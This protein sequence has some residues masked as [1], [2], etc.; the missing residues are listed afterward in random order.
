MSGGT[1]VVGIY[2][3]TLMRRGHRVCVVSLPRGQASFKEKLKS[4]LRGRDSSLRLRSHL[5]EAELDHRVLDVWRPVTD[6]DVPDG[7]IVIATW[8]ETAEWV[9]RLRKEKGAKVYFIQ[10]HEV[11]PHLP[12]RSR[13]TYRLAMHKVVVAQWLK[14]VMISE[15]G[16]EVVDVVPNSVDH[17]QFFAAPREKQHRP[18][19]GLLYSTAPIKGVD[20]AVEAL[21]IVGRSFPDLRIICFGNK[22]IQPDLRL[23]DGSQFF[24][25]PPQSEIRNLY[26]QC[27][28]W[29]TASRTEGFNL[30]A[31]EAMACR[32]PVVST[33]TGWP[34]EAVKSQL[35]GVLVDID[36]LTAF[37]DGIEWI[38][39]RSAAEWRNLSANA[40]ATV[41]S[42][43][44]ESSAAMFERALERACLRAF[45]NEIAGRC[46]CF[47][48]AGDGISEQGH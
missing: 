15:Y 3:Q 28:V 37:V 40:F 30:P 42:S 11:F 13:E 2:A 25:D 5:D 41:S 46:D 19:V 36:D 22:A 38:L 12:A 16:D 14:Q 29:I 1:K 21:K 34:A 32:T 20:L 47:R 45:R 9:S 33:R 17:R 10:G 27:D 23:P 31:M 18:T 44:W 4:L 48:G 35:N 6:D 26:A 8:W 43:S 7:D 24:L 39:T